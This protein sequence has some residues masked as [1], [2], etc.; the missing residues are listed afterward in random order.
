MGATL[1]HT[2]PM[3][4]PI[5]LRLVLVAIVAALV[6][7]VIADR[8][9]LD[10]TVM[11]RRLEALGWIGPLAFLALHV[12]GSLAFLPRIVFGIPAGALWGFAGG[13]GLSVLGATLG[14]VAGLVLARAVNAGWFVPENSPRIG[15]LIERAENEGWRFVAFARLIPFLPHGLTNYAFGLTK[16]AMGP[17]I[18]G[19]VLGILPSNIAYVELGIAGRA[20]MT[21][22]AWIWPT[23]I[24]MV[25]LIGSALLPKAYERWRR[26]R[27]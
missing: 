15:R 10:P 2:G 11:N 24:G 23:A 17:Y 13:L 14:G 1:L 19:T 12:I 5:W 16:V 4:P 3:K 25:L 6:A 8:E 22:T 18:V 20:A 27:A 26:G 7:V 21:G 9:W